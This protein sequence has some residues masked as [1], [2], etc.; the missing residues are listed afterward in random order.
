MDEAS[1]VSIETGLLALMCAKNAVI[2]GDTK[3]L[4]NVRKEDE[5]S[6]LEDIWTSSDIPMSYNTAHDSLLSSVLETLPMVPKTLLREHYRCHPDIINFCN[7]KF[8]DG[9]LLIMTDRCDDEKHLYVLTTVAGHHCRNNYNQREIDAVKLE[10]LP[11]LGNAL[12]H[13]THID[14]LII[15]RVTKEPLLAIETDGY[16]FHNEHTE[17]FERDR[18]KDK[19][20]KLYGLPILRL[21]T[22]GH[23][24]EQKIVDVL[25]QVAT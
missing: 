8:Y 3:Q 9:E 22:V 16:T 4:P 1:Q 14:F 7:Q 11:L 5:K 13:L 10:L 12:H 17:Q 24:E 21:S 19:I 20:L 2:V 18:L 25:N 23:G 6:R 15:N